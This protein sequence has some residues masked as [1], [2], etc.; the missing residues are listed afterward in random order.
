MMVYVGVARCR[1]KGKVGEASRFIQKWVGHRW[2]ARIRPVEPQC[3]PTVRRRVG[4]GERRYENSHLG[5]SRSEES[6]ERDSG[7]AVLPH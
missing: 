2:K 5:R 3:A 6:Q 4:F 1:R 7:A